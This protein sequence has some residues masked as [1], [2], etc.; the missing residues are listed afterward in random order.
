MK[1]QGKLL[2]WG[3]AAVLIAFS[4]SLLFENLW[5]GFWTAFA[6][7]T[8][9]LLILDRSVV[10]GSS[11]KTLIRTFIVLLLITQLLAAI[12]FYNRSDRQVETLQTIRTTIVSNISH[13]EMEKALQHTLRHYYMETDQPEA[14]LENSFRY[15]FEDRMESDGNFLHEATEPDEEMNFTYEIASPDS[16]I[17]AVSATYTPGLNPNF[18]NRSGQSGMYQARTILTKNGVRYE[19][20]N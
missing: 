1:N 8:L 18:E 20:E 11:K 2:V 7:A 14:T 6:A 15:L 10:S 17:L 3:V 4:L 5:V 12:Q 19:R 13:I 9:W 16:I